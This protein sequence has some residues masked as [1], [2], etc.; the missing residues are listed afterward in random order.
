LDEETQ[1]LKSR[2]NKILEYLDK[3]DE[4]K[5][6]DFKNEELPTKPASKKEDSIRNY[7]S[8]PRAETKPEPPVVRQK[9][10]RTASV[11]ENSQ[12]SSSRV[13][14]APEETTK[15]VR[16]ASK[17]SS[18]FGSLGGLPGL[19]GLTK[20]KTQTQ[21]RSESDGFGDIDGEFDLNDDDFD[22]EK[23]DTPSKAVDKSKN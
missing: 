15:P 2:K 10:Q 11:K 22:W 7:V 5:L 17:Q 3:E 12:K 16:Q 1:A 6:E 8:P 14:I 4:L 19:P 23:K 13:N 20:Q 18:G 21:K 9:T